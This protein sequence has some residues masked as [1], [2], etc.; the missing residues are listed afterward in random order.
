MNDAEF[1]VATQST[2]DILVAATIATEVPPVHR[3]DEILGI[4]YEFTT[5]MIPLAI[6]AVADVI[7]GRVL[8]HRFPNDPVAVVLQPKQFSGVGKDYW[9]RAISGHWFPQHVGACLDE[10]HRQRSYELGALWYYSPVSMIPPMSSPP[11]VMRLHEVL[12]PGL[13][14]DYFRFYK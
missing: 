5:E 6:A 14:K 13:S 12:V 3:R 11:W 4:T 10:W 2:R 9:I 1:R 8:N 7:A